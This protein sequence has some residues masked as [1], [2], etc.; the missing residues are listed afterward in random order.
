MHD[1]RGLAALPDP[2]INLFRVL[3]AA[4]LIRFHADKRNA[5]IKRRKLFNTR[6]K[7]LPENIR[8]MA[9]KLSISFLFNEIE[10]VFYRHKCD[11]VMVSPYHL[12]RRFHATWPGEQYGSGKN[13]P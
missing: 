11:C 12:L 3:S 2:R 10:T 9:N 6:P 8:V 1:A 4:F 13:P 5:L 7:P